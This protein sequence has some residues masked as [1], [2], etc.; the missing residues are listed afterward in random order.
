MPRKKTDMPH[1]KTIT[2]GC[3]FNFYETEIA[4]SIVEKLAPTHDVIIINT[5]AVTQEA[6]RQSRQ[7]VRKALRDNPEAKVIVTGCATVT[8]G[9]YFSELDG[10]T[11]ISNSKKSDPKSYVNIAE[12]I[13]PSISNN[14][15]IIEDSDEMFANRVRAFLPIQNGCEHFCTYCIVPYTRGKSQ[16]LPLDVILRRINHFISIGF[17]EVVLSGIDITSYRYDDLTLADIIT[18]ILSETSLERLRISSLDPAGIDKKLFDIM[19]NE[20]RVMPHFHLS[21]QSGDNDVL[22]DMRRRHNRDDVIRLCNNILNKRPDVVFGS[23]FIAGFPTE[24]EDMFENTLKL[25]DEAHLSLLHVFPFSPRTGTVAST[26]IQLPSQIIHERAKILRE[27]AQQA[28]EKLF[29]SLMHKQ[30]TGV[31]EQSENDT[32]FGKTDS[33]VPFKMPGNLLP[34]TII[35]GTVTDFSDESVY[36]NYPV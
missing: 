19:T 11:V 36:L 15:E 1:I 9:K 29:Q 30:I 5:C 28:K 10:I 24:T 14:E 8:S 25:V 33:F 13:V 26:M 2:L 22:K 3:R 7:A 16:S 35:N 20:A 32:S 6:E 23:D 17:N 27:K 18:Q 34:R 4:K 12:K 21:I 31:I